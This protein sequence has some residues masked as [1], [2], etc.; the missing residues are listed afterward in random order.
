MTDNNWYMLSLFAISGCQLNY[1]VV[2]FFEVL[3]I[4][5]SRRIARYIHG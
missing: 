3:V 4:L 2:K 5:L 1:V